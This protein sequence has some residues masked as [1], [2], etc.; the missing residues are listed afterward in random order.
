MLFA[1]GLCAGL[2]SP[3]QISLTL[4]VDRTVVTVGTMPNVKIAVK[5]VSK[6][7]LVLCFG[8]DGSYQ[9][10]R[11]PHLLLETKRY[12]SDWSFESFRGC[13]NKDPIHAEAFT[14]LVP[15]EEKTLVQFE[16]NM[17]L[18]DFKTPGVVQLRFTYDSTPDK[19][20]AW[21]GDE[22]GQ[23]PTPEI[24]RLFSQAVKGKW[25]TETVNIRVIPKT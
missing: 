4:K 3:T 2:M 16:S 13:G 17:G 12:D 6:K 18:D 14:K 7:A 24:A 1:I 15:G 8:M 25:E 19:I 21:Q 11:Y 5:N 23:T 10:A 22:R 20:D 9:G